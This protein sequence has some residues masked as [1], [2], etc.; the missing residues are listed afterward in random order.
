MN[1]KIQL[2][3]SKIRVGQ[4]VHLWQDSIERTD[5]KAH[6]ASFSAQPDNR[7]GLV[8]LWSEAWLDFDDVDPTAPKGVETG[9]ETRSLLPWHSEE[10]G[11]FVE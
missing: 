11:Q 8:F 2:T 7:R 5:A 9:V 1:I 3:N 6:S 10:H 4:G